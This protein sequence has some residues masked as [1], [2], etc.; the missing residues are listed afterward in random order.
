MMGGAANIQARAATLL[1]EGK[2]LLAVEIL[3]KLVYAEP[4][5][6]EAKDVTVQ[7]TPPFQASGHQV[8]ISELA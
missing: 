6:Q 4:E 2:Y 3:N 7:T 8:D 1:Q 5:N